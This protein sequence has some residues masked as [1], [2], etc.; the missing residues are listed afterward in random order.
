MPARDPEEVAE[1]FISYFE[2]DTP[3]SEA[4]IDFLENML[5]WMYGSGGWIRDLDLLHRRYAYR[6]DKRGQQANDFIET[7]S[8]DHQKVLRDMLN[9]RLNVGYMES[10]FLIKGLEIRNG[11]GIQLDLENGLRDDAY[12]EWIYFTSPVQIR[13]VQN[14]STSE[15]LYHKDWAYIQRLEPENW[16]RYIAPIIGAEASESFVTG[17]EW[18][19]NNDGVFVGEMEEWEN[20]VGFV[21]VSLEKSELADAEVTAIHVLRFFQGRNIGKRLLAAAA[22]AAQEA[23]ARSL[24]L[25]TLADNAYTVGFCRKRGGE[26]VAEREAAYA[27]G[28]REIA[29][30]WTDLE[31]LRKQGEVG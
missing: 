27:P 14:E 17:R 19:P 1:N 8:D 23:G 29:F 21:C 26:E 16:R 2:P 11:N 4:Y 18:K 31:A 28:F 25:W 13:A 5:R 9:E 12:L 7:L 30:R 3:E 10:L 15:K 6:R 24:V 20:I 22:G